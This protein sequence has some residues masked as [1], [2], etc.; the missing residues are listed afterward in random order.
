MTT[1]LQA[2]T[3]VSFGGADL[4]ARV[5]G[6][7]WWPARR[8]LA[9]ADMHLGRAERMARQGHGLLPPYETLDTLG[10]LEAEVAA[11]S[12]RVVLSLG[13]SFD[14]LPAADALG[15]EVVTRLARLA[16]GRRLIWIAGNHD[17][18][19]IDLP[20]TYLEEAELGG[21]VFRHIA[22]R[23]DKR[24]EVSAHYHPKVRMMLRGRA[25]SRRCFAMSDCRLILPA[26]GAY[27]GGL[28]VRDRA[29]S[30]LIGP[31][32]VTL[33]IDREVVALPVAQLS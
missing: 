13:D 2:Q 29:L 9:V 22:Q 23:S 24:P 8:V 26:F 30:D 27:T 3:V 5:A 17:P 14:D 21:L 7:L 31:E 4:I 10:R 16:A 6:T 15:E 12:P 20:G 18:G 19:P 1:T 28:D 25:I 11:L 33:V 32:A